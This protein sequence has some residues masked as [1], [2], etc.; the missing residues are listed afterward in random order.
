MKFFRKKKNVKIILGITALLIIPGF[1]IWG[2]GFSK[3]DKSKYA[4]ASVNG[5]IISLIEFSKKVEEE[6]EK[7]REI[8]GEKYEDFIKSMNLEK[9]VLQSLIQEK[10]LLQQARK[11]HIRVSNDEIIEVVKSD[12]SFKDEKGNFNLEKY[13]Q[14]INNLP[15][16]KLKKIEEET[17][18]AILF[19]KLKTQVVPEGSITV[20][21]EE[22]LEFIK[23]HKDYE[24]MDKE[25]IR[26]TLLRQKQEKSFNDW[27]NNIV[28][29]SKI[30][31]YLDFNKQKNAEN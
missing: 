17:K 4:A 13:N 18:K 22:I 2:V 21:D 29:S 23:N 7:Y 5:E 20:K 26:R 25:I 14:I 9:M 27:F 6:T 16:E 31:I 11:R 3:P 15:T 19:Q 30:V 12:P 10:L 8:F 28:K 1:V 24:K